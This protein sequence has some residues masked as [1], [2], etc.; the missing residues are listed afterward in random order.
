MS[1]TVYE[2]PLYGDMHT[3]EVLI[4]QLEKALADLKASE[5]NLFYFDFA[6][7]HIEIDGCEQAIYVIA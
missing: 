1:T 2:G 5:G 7:L 6:G 4:S 3:K